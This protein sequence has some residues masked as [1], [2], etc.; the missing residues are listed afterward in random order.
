LRAVSG[1]SASAHHEAIWEA[2]PAGLEPADYALRRAFLLDRVRAGERVLDIG[3]GEGRFAAALLDA[4]TT[5]VAV[6]VAEEPL[7]RARAACP[8]LDARLVP[9]AGEWPLPDTGVDVAWAGEVLE[10]VTDTAAFLSQVRRVLRPQGRLLLSTPAHPLAL[11]LRVAL[12]ARAFAAHFDPLGDHLR[13]YTRA[14]LR[15]LLEE[16]GFE[17][18]SVRA[19]GRPSLSGRPLLLASAVRSRF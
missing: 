7:R 19:A 3:C 18:V 13:F 12:S 5:A 10:H 6:D 1:E 15:G 8:G 11:R 4:G 14:G 17:R 9:V 2:L 16:F